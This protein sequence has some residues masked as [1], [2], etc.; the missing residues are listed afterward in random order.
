[1]GRQCFPRVLESEGRSGNTAIAFR[2]ITASAAGTSARAGF[3]LMEVLLALMILGV[4]TQLAAP[5]MQG[6]LKLQRSPVNYYQDEI[7]VYQLQLELAVNDIMEVKPD[8]IVYRSPENVCTL[9]IVNG[10]LISQPGTY[11]FIHGIKHVEFE[12]DDE[13]IYMYYTRNGHEF[14]W[15]LGYYAP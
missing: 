5:L 12:V 9:H 13:V 7:G 8:C 3:T 15:P 14:R 2:R 6:L 10:K 11:D 1:M 4:L